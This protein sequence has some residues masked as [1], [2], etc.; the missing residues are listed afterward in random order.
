METVST[1]SQKTLFQQLKNLSQLHIKQFS[2]YILFACQKNHLN[3]NQA[4][5][6]FTGSHAQKH[7]KHNHKSFCLM[8]INHT[9][10][11]QQQFI[12]RFKPN[13]SPNQKYTLFQQVIFSIAAKGMPSPIDII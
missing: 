6:L 2:E 5:R 4:P 8:S 3:N 7:L 9:T 11:Q 13:K 12:L 10:P 1:I